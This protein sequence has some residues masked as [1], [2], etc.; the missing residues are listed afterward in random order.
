MYNTPE[1]KPNRL[2]RRTEAA[3]LRTSFM[4]DLKYLQRL[5]ND[6]VN[7]I[8][9][10]ALKNRIDKVRKAGEKRRAVRKNI[11]LEQG[12]H[13]TRVVIIGKL[14]QGEQV[15][16]IIKGGKKNNALYVTGVDFARNK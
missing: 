11:G 8:K 2:T 10:M 9:R 12:V 5:D 4:R 15:S 14:V 13:W 3:Q 6:A 16:Y 1:L 7:V